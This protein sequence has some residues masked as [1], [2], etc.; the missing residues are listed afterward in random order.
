M[1]YHKRVKVEHTPLRDL[2]FYFG[3]QNKGLSIVRSFLLVNTSKIV[4]LF[5]LAVLKPTV[6]QLRQLIV[7]ALFDF[8]E[9][10]RQTL[11]L[12]ALTDKTFLT[13]KKLDNE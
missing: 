10:I 4:L 9:S 3:A 6:R 5:L 13:Q 1:V 11:K 2:K 8:Q 7:F 12:L